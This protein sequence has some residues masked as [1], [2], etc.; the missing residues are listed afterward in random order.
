VETELPG[1][2]EV[3]EPESWAE[4]SGSAG[5]A[6]LDSAPESSMD[7]LLAMP[8]QEPEVT[9]EDAE[10]LLKALETVSDLGEPSLEVLGFDESLPDFA[11]FSA[12][13][14]LTLEE[15]NMFAPDSDLAH[16]STIAEEDTSD[17]DDEVDFSFDDQLPTWL[18]HSKDEHSDHAQMTP[19]DSSDI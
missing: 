18:R 8:D 7:D 12:E 9:S 13:D 2:E 16:T 3:F 11:E 17:E 1:G 19:D 14:S 5:S 4:A 10:D 15:E 6:E